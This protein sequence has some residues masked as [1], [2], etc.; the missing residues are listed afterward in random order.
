MKTEA[1]MDQQSP[2]KHASL[3]DSFTH[4]LPYHLL[5]P[6][7]VDKIRLVNVMNL[8]CKYEGTDKNALSEHLLTYGELILLFTMVDFVHEKLAELR[9]LRGPT[10]TS[11]TGEF[12]SSRHQSVDRYHMLTLNQR[13]IVYSF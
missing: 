10:F 12:H 6:P 9:D 11:F 3:S 8:I 1:S 4:A 7:G 5:P 2:M 13:T